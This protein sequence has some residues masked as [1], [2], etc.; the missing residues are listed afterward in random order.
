MVMRIGDV[1]ESALLPLS[2]KPQM[3]FDS[4]FYVFLSVKSLHVLV[5]ALW[6]GAGAFI[7]LFLLP[8]AGSLAP[9][10]ISRL[11][12]RKFHLFMAFVAATTILSGLLLYWHLTSGFSAIALRSHAGLT[13]G[14]GGALGIVAAIIG[15][16]VVGKSAARI[17]NLSA[18]AAEDE[19]AGGSQTSAAI[20]M[21]RRRM[22][23]GGRAVVALMAATLVLMTLGHSI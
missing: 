6:L 10:V 11:S 7:T 20:Q 19:N 1:A 13:F 16:N 5:A 23:M 3:S 14:V 2:W 12:R 21:L 22:A 4:L 9:E 18:Q 17:A 8:A 15:R